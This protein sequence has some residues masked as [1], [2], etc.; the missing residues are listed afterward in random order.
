MLLKELNL[1][2][3]GKFKNENIVLKDGI[4]LI[5]GENEAG[6]STLHS[7]IDGMFYGFLKPNIKRTDYLPEYEKYNP[8]NNNRYAGIIRFKYNGK[9]YR[10]ERNFTKG[11]ENTKVLDETTG[12]DITKNIEAGS[13]RVLQPGIHFF[14]FNT[15]VFSNTIFIKQL[16]TKTDDKLAAEVTEKLINVTT[17]LDDN[18]S[19]DKA[20]SELKV[21]MGEIGTDRASTKPY[22]KNLRDIERLQEEKSNILS[23]KDAYQSYLEEKIRLNN[24]LEIEMR[25]L[26]RLREKLSK[27]EILEKA[28]TLEEAKILSGEIANLN[29]KIDK[30]SSYANISMDQYKESINLSNAIDFID[31]NIVQSK[32]ELENIENRLGSM[33][34]ERYNDIYGKKIEEISKDYNYYEELEEEK[35]TIFYNKEDN[36]IEFLKRDYK[37]LKGKSSKYRVIQI[38]SIIL[39]I[40]A[41]GFAI[42]AIIT[43]K[44]IPI[45]ILFIVFGSIGGYYTNKVNNLKYI[46]EDISR[47]IEDIYNREKEKRSRIE[48]IEKLKK[49][50]LEKYNTTGKMELKKLLDRLQIEYYRQKEQIELYNELKTKRGFLLDRIYEDEFNKKQNLITLEAIFTENNVRDIQEF[51]YSLDK[52]NMYEQY[53]RESEG[54]KE[55]LRKVL[56]QD[57]IEN[58]IAELGNFYLDINNGIEDMDKNQIK[59]QIDRINEN[60]SDIKIALRGAEENLNIL[61]KNIER[62]IVIE[63]EIERK[64]KYKEELENKYKSLEIAAQAI[65]E[66]SRDIHS[67]F[68]PA[69]N[70]KVSKIVEKITEGKYNNIKISES[71]NIS[72]ENP[73]TREIIDINS[74]SGGT[75]DQLYFSLRFGIINSMVDNKLPL[76]LDDCF[77]QYDDSRLKNI[78]E[79]LT[80]I[81]NER[82][83]ILFTCHNREKKALED[84]GAKFN[85][86]NLK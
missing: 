59:Y 33:D 52:R 29:S 10:I 27:V 19:V 5:Y 45:G 14:G 74:L 60:I 24:N 1:I 26:S 3:F 7:F 78:I 47:K 75:I 72:V 53:I 77:I 46:I 79:F 42:I 17:T 57:T 30:L 12:V 15:R 49:S 56:G 61:G 6:K 84:L 48:E 71:L 39:A 67:Q 69:I 83:V 62:L 25:N 82:Q 70:K 9:F 4:N 58:L 22:A 11:E 40:I 36:K 28:R 85:L 55:I 80:D 8:W 13:G 38:F 86:I 73:I 65:E 81:G 63:E 32:F 34:N 54:K 76:I 2:G 21:R 35:N 51:N 16:G 64:I 41:F 18:I 20:I 66:L 37:E 31:K 50:L 43:K 68:T 23:E 44:Y